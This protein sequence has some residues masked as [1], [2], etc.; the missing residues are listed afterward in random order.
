MS[1]VCNRVRTTPGK[2]AHGR[3][4]PNT[5]DKVNSGTSQET[6]PWHGP[7]TREALKSRARP[8]CPPSWHFAP[9]SPRNSNWGGPHNFRACVRTAHHTSPRNPTT[10]PTQQHPIHNSPACVVKMS[11]AEANPAVVK[12]FGSGQR[13]VPHPSNKARK[14]Y[15]TSDELQ[16]KKVS[17]NS[18]EPQK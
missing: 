7:L 4:Q 18:Q 1:K 3:T 10:H 6:K 11:A 9:F 8:N 13:S 16:P 17:R 2:P 12:K 14:W 15:P 5:A